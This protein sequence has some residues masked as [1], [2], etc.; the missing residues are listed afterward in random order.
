MTTRDEEST[1]QRLKKA[2]DMWILQFSV[3][4]Y[5]ISIDF[6]GTKGQVWLLSL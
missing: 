2:V 4:D 3:N 5:T 1:P 6:R